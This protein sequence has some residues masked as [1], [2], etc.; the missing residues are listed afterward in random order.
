LETPLA[1][2]SRLLYVMYADQNLNPGKIN[3]LVGATDRKG[4]SLMVGIDPQGRVKLDKKLTPAIQAP[5]AP[6]TTRS[7]VPPMAGRTGEIAPPPKNVKAAR[8]GLQ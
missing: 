6:V 5:L 7:G 3:I 2:L 1:D 4:E 8:R